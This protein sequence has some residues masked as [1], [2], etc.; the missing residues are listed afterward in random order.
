M[1]VATKLVARQLTST[2]NA[3]RVL[4]LSDATAVFISTYASLVSRLSLD[5]T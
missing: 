2:R 3:A 1:R 5:L 4:G